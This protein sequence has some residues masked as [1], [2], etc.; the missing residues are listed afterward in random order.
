MRKKKILAF[1][2]VAAVCTA[3]LTF[4]N[5]SPSR[6]QAPAAIQ[7]QPAAALGTKESPSPSN[8]PEHVIYGQFF[9]H[10]KA[11]RERAKEVERQG[12]SGKALRSHYKEK[13]GLKD[14][15]SRVLDKITD[16]YEA[17]VGRLD[18]QAKKLIDAAHARFPNGVVPPGAT[19]PPPPP[20]LKTLQRERDMTAMKARHKL[21]AVLG[22]HGFRQIDDYIKL[23]FA[24]GV[25]PAQP[26]ARQAVPPGQLPPAGGVQ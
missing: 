25:R 19:L 9:R 11:I 23:N 7:A 22:E 14:E 3:A 13:I 21:R 20:E 4:N 8:A 1:L 15:H 2:C 17:E 16:E 5:A 6:G 12:R 10:A 24:R 18:A 26:V